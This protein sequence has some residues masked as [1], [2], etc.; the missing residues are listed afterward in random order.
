GTMQFKG[1]IGGTSLGQ[2]NDQQVGDVYFVTN[3]SKLYIWDGSEW[4]QLTGADG[5]TG[6]TGATG[7]AGA[8]GQDGADGKS[9][10]QTAVDGGYPGTA[11]QFAAKLAEDTYSRSETD[12]AI[13]DA[14]ADYDDGLFTVVGEDVVTWNQQNS[15]V[16]AFLDYLAEHPYSEAQDSYSYFDDH[17]ITLNDKPGAGEITTGAGTLTVTDTYNR[18][19]LVKAVTAGS[20][21]V[22]NLIPYRGTAVLRDNLT[23]RQAVT[24]LPTGHVRMIDVGTSVVN[25]RDLGGW[26]CDGGTVKYGKL[27]RSGQLYDAQNQSA[28][29]LALARAVLVEQCGV[30]HDLDLRGQDVV[31]TASPLGNDIGYTRPE[32]YQYYRIFDTTQTA[33]NQLRATWQS[34]LFCIFTQIAAGH[35]LVFHCASGAD[36]T[37]AVA[38]ILEALL[39]VSRD[40]I[41]TDYELTSFYAIRKRT[42]EEWQRL[43]GQIE[44]LEGTTFSD[45]VIGWVKSLGFTVA[46]INAFRAAMIDGT[47]T[48]IP[49]DPDPTPDPDPDPEPTPS[50]TN[51]ADPTSADWLTGYRLN[52]SAQPTECEGSIVTNKV[53]VTDG[54]TI[55]IKNLAKNNPNGNANVVCGLTSTGDKVFALAYTSGS[56]DAVT[57]IVYDNATNTWTIVLA[58]DARGTAYIRVGAALA[59][60]CTADDVIITINEVIDDDD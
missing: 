16:Q 41:D 9:A 32:R 27:F 23:V 56:N 1:S 36:R 46:E 60:G 20:Q 4:K 39:G 47:P 18:R 17:Q 35:P 12:D 44:T 15:S 57:S 31:D 45:K 25:V 24:L 22:K 6:A 30:Q 40:D 28:T 42:K 2:L 5:A 19:S 50:Y 10:Y 37:G 34:I 48:I 54:D 55:R 58:A 49:D 26:D 29:D 43:I 11:A 59:S 13:A 14:I 3:D 53:A 51:L 8:D 33:T 21:S 38:C 7:A 52:S